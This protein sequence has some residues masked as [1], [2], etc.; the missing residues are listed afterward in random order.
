[1]SAEK[2]TIYGSSDDLIEVTGAVTDELNPPYGKPAVV[3]VDRGGR[4]FAELTLE[5]DPDG[6]GCW[7][8]KVSSIPGYAT[9]TAARGEDEPDDEDGC[10]GH[11]DKATV[12]TIGDGPVSVRLA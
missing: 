2:V 5:F 4:R 11:S 1:M 10:P 6:S 9:L 3:Y 7:R 12:L 8:I